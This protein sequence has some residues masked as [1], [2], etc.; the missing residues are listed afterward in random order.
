MSHGWQACVCTRFSGSKRNTGRGKSGC[1]RGHDVRLKQEDYLRAT[2]SVYY[3]SG[4]VEAAIFGGGGGG[5]GLGV[6]VWWS[7]LF[8]T[9]KIEMDA[10][11]KDR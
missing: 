9:L 5:G 7:Q 11:Q 3:E 6:S 2:R 10:D 4:V 1:G 8:P